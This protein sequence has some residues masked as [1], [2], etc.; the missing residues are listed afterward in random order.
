MLNKFL[1]LLFILV[2]SFGKGQSYIDQVNNKDYKDKEQFEKF[3][4]KRKAVGNWQINQLKKGALVIKLKTNQKLIDELIKKGKKEMAESKRLE[5]FVINRSIMSAFIDK[6]TFCK[7]YF[8]YSHYSD[9]LLNGARKGI[10]VDTNL[11]VD[12]NI[13]MKE[14]FYLIGER[15]RIYNSS[16]GFVPE[17]SARIVKERGNPSGYD[18]L[19]VVKN[20]YGHQLKKPFPYVCGYG[21]K[22]TGVLS[23]TFVKAVPVYY[24]SSENYTYKVLIDKTQLIDYKNNEKKQFKKAPEGAMT[25]MLKKEFTYEVLS[26]GIERFNDE[27]NA[28]YQASPPVTDD[29]IPLEIK[30]FLY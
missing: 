1:T 26:M 25:Y 28:Y 10:F 9:S 6:F 21:L 8:I 24:Y 15:D 7:V 14:T 18:V 17:D 30:K 29:R 22:N 20:K 2:L 13:E 3:Y 19:A 23:S 27:M 12:P 11:A 16:I 5:T 4:K